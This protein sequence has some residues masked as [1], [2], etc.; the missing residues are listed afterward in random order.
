MI[1]IADS[2]STKCH[3]AYLAQNKKTVFY[4]TIGLNPHFL[5]NSEILNEL[6]QSDLFS[7]RKSVNKV[8]F[9]GAG[10][11]LENFKRVIYN[12]FKDFFINAKIH[13][14]HDLMGACRSTLKINN[15]NCIIGTGSIACLYDGLIASPSIPSLG[16]IIGD[17]GSG[18]Y[19][20]KKL[21]NLYFT[22]RLPLKIKDDFEKKY[23]LSHEILLKNIYQN[24]RA[25][26]YLSSFFPF[27]LKYEY[28]DQILDEG[29]ELFLKTHVFCIDKYQDYDINFIGSVAYFLKDIII[30]KSF[31]YNFSAVSCIKNPI[32]ELVKYHS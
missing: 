20:G 25:N 1:L 31:E 30:K 24:N 15:I 14:E 13:V 3:W 6:N 10:C 7:I 23:Q 18:N 17:E 27:L 19:F 2:G 5:S 21:I 8:F 29:V 12:S 9:Y 16:F 11:S 28:F 22:N 4:N 26:S 32:N